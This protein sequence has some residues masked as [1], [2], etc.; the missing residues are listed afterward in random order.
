MTYPATTYAEGVELTI[1]SGNQL[2]EI[3]NGDATEEISTESGMVPSLRK[4]L[5]DSMLFK[6][7]I[8]W[9]E[10][11]V[12]SDPF[13]ARIFEGY[14]YWAPTASNLTPIS[15]GESP[16]I[17]TNWFLLPIYPIAKT[18]ADSSE[19]PTNPLLNIEVWQEDIDKKIIYRGD[20]T[21]KDMLGTVV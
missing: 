18:I 7:A 4:A 19:R 14:L 6:P 15:M 1:T 3:I 2:H 10:G 8:A 20:S 17:D 9:A 13:Q 5:A 11:S 12:E 21:W 16:L